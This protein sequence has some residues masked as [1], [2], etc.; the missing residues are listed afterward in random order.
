[1]PKPGDER[2]QHQSQTI[3]KREN[4]SLAA[5]RTFMTQNVEDLWAQG[6][7]EDPV[8]GEVL[9][10]LRNGGKR[11]RHLSIAE[12]SENNDKLCYQERVYVSDL[13][14]LKLHLIQEHHDISAAEHSGRA[15]TLKLLAR[16][17]FWPGMRKD[18]DRYCRN[19]HPCKR[20]QIARHAP[21][22]SL[23]PLSIPEGAWQNISMDFVTELPWSDGLNA[24][25][26]IVCRLTKMRHLILC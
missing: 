20:S 10:T 17:Y 26:M 3:L 11:S 6:Y 24:V 2:L 5:A 7:A 4:L 9:Q 25:L 12:C 23:H 1:M 13:M 16:R 21:Y 8:P 18:V 19:C 15:K 14:S 22:G